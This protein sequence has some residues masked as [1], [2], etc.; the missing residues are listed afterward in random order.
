MHTK[1]PLPQCQVLQLG[2][3]LGGIQQPPVPRHRQAGE[4]GQAVEDGRVDVP[5]SLALNVGAEDGHLRVNTQKKLLLTDPKSKERKRRGTLSPNGAYR[6][7]KVKKPC[8]LEPRKGVQQRQ[9][10]GADVHQGA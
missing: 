5:R 6:P 10:V 2:G 1:M 4:L 7:L 3:K 8:L 9:R